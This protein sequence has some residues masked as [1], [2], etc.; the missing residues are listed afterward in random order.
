MPGVEVVEELTLWITGLAEVFP[1]DCVSEQLLQHPAFAQM[2]AS[3]AKSATWGKASLWKVPVPQRTLLMGWWTHKSP[4]SMGHL[5]EKALQFAQH[6]CYLYLTSGGAE[7]GNDAFVL[8][9]ENPC[10]S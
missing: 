4:V 8:K 6:S 1:R 3:L 7:E 10:L 2:C 5:V 9:N